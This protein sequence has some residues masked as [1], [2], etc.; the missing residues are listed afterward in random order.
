VDFD[1]IMQGLQR[2]LADTI[3][4]A[5]RHARTPPL[6]P[7]LAL[8]RLREQMREDRRQQELRTARFDAKM[9]EIDERL[10]RLPGYLE[11]LERKRRPRQ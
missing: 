7:P 4:L 11:Y 6:P 3:E 10:K 9:R 1:A 8:D 5:H 2:T